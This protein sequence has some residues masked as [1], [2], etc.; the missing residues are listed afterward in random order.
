MTDDWLRVACL[1]SHGRC[2][3]KRHFCSVLLLLLNM[4]S[5]GG[6]RFHSHWFMRSQYCF[7][8]PTKASNFHPFYISNVFIL[9]SVGI[10]LVRTTPIIV[11]FWPNCRFVFNFGQLVGICR[12]ALFPH[13][14]SQFLCNF[15][16]A[17]AL[18]FATCSVKCAINTDPIFHPRN[19]AAIPLHFYN[20][21]SCAHWLSR[22]FLSF[23]CVLN[24]K[25][26]VFGV[27]S[28]RKPY[29]SSSSISL[30]E[31]ARRAAPMAGHKKQAIQVRCVSSLQISVVSKR[32]LFAHEFKPS[33]FVCF[34]SNWLFPKLSTC[35]DSI[36]FLIRQNGVCSKHC[37]AIPNLPFFDGKI[38]GLLMITYTVLPK[39]FR[40]IV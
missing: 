3:L 13:N 35:F 19:A 37:S 28:T 40:L 29:S 27:A 22:V 18:M 6:F 24:I 1:I 2:C 33:R 17:T 20:Q 38:L 14:S 8:F 32:G 15:Q 12:V 9:K 11:Y 34:I 30:L 31:C 16:C 26:I 7:Q 25:V 21:F 23:Q 36:R 5:V 10:T 4:A 39:S